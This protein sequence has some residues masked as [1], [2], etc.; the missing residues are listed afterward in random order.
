MGEPALEL[1]L[2]KGGA[3]GADRAKLLEGIWDRKGSLGFLEPTRPNKVEFQQVQDLVNQNPYA[4]AAVR[5][6]NMMPFGERAEFQ[7]ELGQCDE[8][9]PL[10]CTS[11]PPIDFRKAAAPMLAYKCHQQEKSYEPPQPVPYTVGDLYAPP[12]T[13]KRADAMADRAAWYGRQAPGIVDAKALVSAID[14]INNRADLSLNDRTQILGDLCVLMCKGRNRPLDDNTCGKMALGLAQAIAHPPE[15][16]TGDLQM[17][18]TNPSK[19]A[20]YVTAMA[21]RGTAQYAPKDQRQLTNDGKAEVAAAKSPQEALDKLL[22]STRVVVPPHIEIDL[23]KL[24]QGDGSGVAN[25]SLSEGQ[26]QMLIDIHN[27]DKRIHTINIS[28]Q[29]NGDDSVRIELEGARIE[30]SGVGKLNL[31]KNLSMTIHRNADG[32]VEL[33]KIEGM[34]TTLADPRTLKLGK[35]DDPDRKIIAVVGWHSTERDVT[36]EVPGSQIAQFDQM[37]RVLNDVNKQRER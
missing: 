13:K 18:R 15:G 21:T 16:A 23:R 26:K 11:K 10:E 2:P 22:G 4:A 25:F 28:H 6:M 31:A 35:A 19:L 30:G 8:F 17:A 24:D 29:A 36:N 32:S 3:N 7:K 37:I 14:D 27:Q 34:S 9:W 1:P 12:A 33:Q 20:D 5:Q